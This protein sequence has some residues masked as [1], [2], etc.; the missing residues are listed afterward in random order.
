MFDVKVFR[1]ASGLWV[2]KTQS[3]Y[4]LTAKKTFVQKV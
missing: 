3:G 4:Y 1:K 2:L